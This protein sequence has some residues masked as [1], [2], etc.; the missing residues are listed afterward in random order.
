MKILGEGKGW[1]SWEDDEGRTHGEV[2]P[3]PEWSS[4]DWEN[5]TEEEREFHWGESIDAVL[6]A[7]SEAWEKL[8]KL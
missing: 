5:M 7:H 8:A 1:R 2:W 3:E 6:K 4:T